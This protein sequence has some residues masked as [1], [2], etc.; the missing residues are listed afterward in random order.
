MAAQLLTINTRI[1]GFAIYNYNTGS[2]LISYGLSARQ[3]LAAGILS[4]IVL[5]IMCVLCGVSLC[6]IHMFPPHPLPP[7]VTPLLRF[8]I[9]LP[10]Y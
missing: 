10:K 5:A 6:L 9:Y 3:C 7:P 1:A 2:A 8:Q 4:P